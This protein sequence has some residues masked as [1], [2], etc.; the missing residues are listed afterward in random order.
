[1]TFEAWRHYAQTRDGLWH[2]HDV[3]MLTHANPSTLPTTG[4]GGCDI[5][6]AKLHVSHQ[7]HSNYRMGALCQKCEGAA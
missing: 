1:V 5:S 2:R 4:R 3:V 7:P 6:G